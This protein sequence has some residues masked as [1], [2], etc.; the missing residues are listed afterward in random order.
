LIWAPVAAATFSWTAILLTNWTVRLEHLKPELTVKIHK[1]T[2]TAVIF[3]ETPVT[4]VIF[5]QAIG[6][7]VR[8]IAWSLSG[9]NA[10]SFA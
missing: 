7:W 10:M 1:I 9:F 8:R 6:T 5:C 2:E 3:V 4:F